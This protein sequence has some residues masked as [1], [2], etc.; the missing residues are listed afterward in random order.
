MKRFAI[1]LGWWLIG[2]ALP[3]SPLFAREVLHN[4]IE[5]PE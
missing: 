2:A 5:L 3:C 1:L 4:G